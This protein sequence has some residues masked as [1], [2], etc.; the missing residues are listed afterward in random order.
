MSDLLR[1]W[2]ERIQKQAQHFEA[3]AGQVLQF[4]TEIIANAAKVKVLRNEHSQLKARQE[5]IDQSVQHI[6]EQQESLSRLLTGLQEVLRPSPQETE[7]SAALAS[8]PTVR[9]HLRAQALTLHLDELERQTE[10]LARETGVV[11][12]ALYAEPLTTVVRVLDSH[13]EALDGLQLQVG[14]LAH[15]LHCIETSL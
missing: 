9:S 8:T 10:D 14:S 13:A 3:F 5:A 12:S 2:E 11:Q 1:L 15:R 6:W 7:F 4:D